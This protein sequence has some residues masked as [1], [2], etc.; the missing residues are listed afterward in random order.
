MQDNQ[1][2]IVQKQVHQ[3]SKNILVYFAPTLLKLSLQ[4]SAVP[5][6]ECFALKIYKV[7]EMYFNEQNMLR[8]IQNKTFMT[9]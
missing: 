2:F 3:A 4:D 8:H 7:F 5:Q 1:K 9:T 6:A